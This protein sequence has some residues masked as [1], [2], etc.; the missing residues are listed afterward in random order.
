MLGAL[1][2]RR[3]LSWEALW[4]PDSSSCIPLRA[5]TENQTSGFIPS[6][7]TATVFS[8]QVIESSVPLLPHL[9]SVRKGGCEHSQSI[10]RWCLHIESDQWVSLL[11]FKW[12]NRYKAPGR[13][14][15]PRK[16]PM[17]HWPP[18]LAQVEHPKYLS[19]CTSLTPKVAHSSGLSSTSPQAFQE[20]M[21]LGPGRKSPWSG[22]RR[23]DDGDTSSIPQ[24]GELRTWGGGWSWPS[25]LQPAQLPD[26]HYFRGGSGEDGARHQKRGHLLRTHLL[27]H[28]V[29]PFLVRQHPV[30]YMH[31]LQ[32]D[33]LGLNAKYGTYYGA[34][35]G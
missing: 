22:W 9:H 4:W 19:T 35:F 31:G 34:S 7:P 15:D 10:Y 16:E 26:S 12:G 17:T 29:D 18:P 13:E 8:E 11:S 3:D 5:W 25:C 32:T 14:P 6:P 33:C 28:R 20:Q 21:L 2:A 1:R 27:V 23:R 24:T 30:S